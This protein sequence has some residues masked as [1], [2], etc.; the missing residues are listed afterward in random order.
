MI[1]N[2][3]ILPDYHLIIETKR[4][5]NGRWNSSL[6]Y[7]IGTGGGGHVLDTDSEGF[8]TERETVINELQRV[9]AHAIWSMKYHCENL[10]HKDDEGNPIIRKPTRE[11]IQRYIEMLHRVEKRLDEPIQLSLF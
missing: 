6:D 3:Q 5:D 7:R 1:I 8:S 10:N 11:K 4:L 2:E 9:Y